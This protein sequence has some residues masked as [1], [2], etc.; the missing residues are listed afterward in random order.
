MSEAWDGLPANPERDG[1]HWLQTP[2][3]PEVLWWDFDRWVIYRG[4]DRGVG[5]PRWAALRY[6]Y[7]GP[8]LTP[9]EVSERERAAYAAGAEAMRER[10]AEACMRAEPEPGRSA[11]AACCA[12]IRALPVPERDA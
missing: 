12:A 5:S 2:Q 11:R 9:A 7:L 4:E 1:W 10:A 3:S 6:V 8:C